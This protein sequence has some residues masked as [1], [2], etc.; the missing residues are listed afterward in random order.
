MSNWLSY[1]KNIRTF[2]L[3]FNIKNLEPLHVGSG[4]V[5]NPFSP[6]YLTVMKL[7]I[8]GRELPIIPGSSLKGLLR[9]ISHYIC[10]SGENKI[11]TCEI[12][13][14][15][16]CGKKYRKE[17]EEGISAGEDSGVKVLK[18][19]CVLCKLYGTSSYASRLIMMDGRLADDYLMEYRSGIAIN[20]LTGE[21]RKGSLFEYESIS[22]GCVFSCRAYL[23]NS[24]NYLLG[25]LAKSLMM[26]DKGLFKLGGFKSRGH[27]LVRVENVKV[28][29]VLYNNGM[30]MKLADGLVPALDEEDSE[31]TLEPSIS[32]RELASLWDAYVSRA[33][34]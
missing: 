31:F 28:S 34:S 23:V 26:I 27:G 4:K 11:Q 33:K 17:I 20:R 2:T 5:S 14:D 30:Y 18:K 3:D 32:L 19:L 10:N 13:T 16:E 29:I 9:S 1:S 6:V 15:N 25:L 7:N 22:P 21:T 24:P 12:G 8:G